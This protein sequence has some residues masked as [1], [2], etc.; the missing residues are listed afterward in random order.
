MVF[1]FRAKIALL[2]QF[3]PT[4]AHHENCGPV[5]NVVA[6]HGSRLL[7]GG[8]RPRAR[9]NRTNNGRG[10]GRPLSRQTGYHVQHKVCCRSRTSQVDCCLP[11]NFLSSRRSRR[12]PR[13]LQWP[14]KESMQ[15][16]IVWVWGSVTHG[17]AV[18]QYTWAL[19]V[20]IGTL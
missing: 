1:V 10:E 19:S 5:S 2:G 18:E 7:K 14:S 11:R 13:L 12:I 16:V 8:Y 9:A 4:G 17:N 20:L 6:L 15:E 3:P